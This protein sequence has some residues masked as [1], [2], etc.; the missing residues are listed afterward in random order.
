VR[1]LE[2]VSLSLRLRTSRYDPSWTIAGAGVAAGV[3]AGDGRRKVVVREESLVIARA[4]GRSAS[5]T[6]AG[7]EGRLDGRKSAEGRI[8][9]M[10]G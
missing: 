3:G 8:A 10:C 2:T 4:V 6:G 7:D 1:D 5:A 9:L